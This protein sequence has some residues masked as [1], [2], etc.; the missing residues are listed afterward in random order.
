MN[1]SVAVPPSLDN[2]D[3]ERAVGILKA[4]YSQVSGSS[5][6]TG[7]AWDSFD[8]S[9]TRF[10]STNRYTADDL[11]SCALLS[12][13]IGGRAAIELLSGQGAEFTSLL[14][15]IGPDRDFI[16][17]ESPD[18][19]SFDAVRALFRALVALPG[20]GETRATKL[21][22]RKRPRLVPIVDGVIKR[23][24]FNGASR[25]WA[26][27]HAALSANER[28]LWN[29]LVE[30]RE[31]AG[32]SETVSVLRVFDVLAW[33]DGSGNSERVRE[34]DP[35]SIDVPGV[36]DDASQGLDE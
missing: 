21:L 23:T 29:R 31:A 26:P 25:H 14:E 6:Y 5:G 9:G 33:M 36:H 13:P 34:G 30:A 8:P 24:V 3:P 7:G 10:S 18:T 17:V 20:V 1:K 15:A 35:I 11:I 2:P 32:L 16:D 19:S 27:L 28:A 4:Y 22:A 12:T